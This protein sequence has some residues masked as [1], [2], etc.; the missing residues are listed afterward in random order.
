MQIGEADQARYA[1]Q[2]DRGQF[3]RSLR[4][5]RRFAPAP[6]PEDVLRE[7]LDIGRWTGSAKNTQPWQVVVVRDRERLRQLSECGTF[8]S[9]LAGAA[10]GLV[11][12]MDDDNRRLDE[13]RLAQNL[14]LAAWAYGIGSCIATMQ[15]EENVERAKRLLGIPIA[16]GVH[17]VLALG[18]L[19]DP[20]AL[21][22]ELSGVEAGRKPM[23]EFLH[24]ETFSG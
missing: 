18:Y 3:I 5:V 14:M 17:T 10:S 12:V 15:P 7:V 6:I 22:L 16:R 8:A 13:G 23:A 24:W 9:H 11:L 4:S 20:R 2:S 19:A 1:Q 21:R